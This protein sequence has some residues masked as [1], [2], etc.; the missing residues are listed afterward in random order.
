MDI[1]SYSVAAKQKQR[2]EQIIANPDSTSGI[3]T[4]PSVI[5]TGETITI[6]AG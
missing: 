4:T 3:V 6:P 5:A 1:V 2:I